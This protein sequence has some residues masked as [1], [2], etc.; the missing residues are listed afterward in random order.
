MHTA[1]EVGGDYY[2]F[3]VAPDGTLTVAIGDATGHGTK[4][5]TMVVITK[6][7]F[8]DFCRLPDLREIF[9]KYTDNIK[10]LNLPSLYMAMLMVRIRDHTL[11]ASS[12][13]MPAPL[14]YRGATG[15]VE[16]VRLKGMPLGGF[17]N[18]PYE[19]KEVGLFPGDTIVL[20][21]DG[22][23]EMF[24]KERQTFGDDRIKDIIRE[25]GAEPPQRLI[26]RLLQA[27]R[28]WA[29]GTPQQDDVT[30]VVLQVKGNH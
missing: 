29:N 10:R 13:G 7:L 19:Q 9:A 12:A 24:N 4:A 27:G 5:G 20:M 30:F 21:S 14:I 22:L 6:S 18:F 16:E 3:A 28:E 2:D 1:T 17:L 26:D 11:V 25:A 23:P 15:E 8:H